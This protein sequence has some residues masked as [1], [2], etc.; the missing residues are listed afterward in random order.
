MDQEYRS[1]CKR[2]EERKSASIV[3]VDPLTT[4]QLLKKLRPVFLFLRP[5]KLQNHCPI[6][7]VMIKGT[8]E[9]GKAIK[10]EANHIYKE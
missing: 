2:S 5:Q 1:K 8:K 7:L 4:K 9:E 6:T 10:A 3:V